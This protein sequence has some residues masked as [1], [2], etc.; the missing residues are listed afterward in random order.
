MIQSVLR[1]SILGVAVC[2]L[3]AAL[4]STAL[5]QDDIGEVVSKIKIS[6]TVGNFQEVLDD[7]DQFGRSLVDLGD[8]NG[9]SVIDVLV[10]AHADDDGGEDHGAVYVMFMASIGKVSTSQKISETSGG[11]TGNLHDFD[12]FGRAAVNLGDLDGD[13]VTD[14]A[15][16]VNYDNEGGFNRGS[17]YVLFLNT[18]GTVKAQQ[19]ISSTEGG[20]GG[21]LD[22]GDEFGRALARIGDLDGDGVTELGVGSY[23]D[24]GGESRGAV[25]ILNLNTN[26]TVKSWSKISSTSGNLPGPLDNNDFFGHAVCALGDIDADGLGDIA[27]GAPL[28]DDGGLNR[29]AVYVLT[30]TAAGT[31]ESQVKISDTQGGFTGVLDDIDQFGVSLGQV[32]DLDGDGVKELAAGAVK[33]DDGGTERGAVWILLLNPDRSVKG[34]AKISDTEGGFN[35]GLGDGD[36]LGSCIGML[37][38]TAPGGLGEIG[39][40]ARFDDD[41][42]M[43]R[44]SV[45]LLRLKDSTNSAPTAGFTASPTSGPAPLTVDF[46]DISGGLVDAWDWDFGDG[47]SS[48][49][50]NPSHQFALPGSYTVSLTV[51]GPGGSDSETKIGFVTVL[52]PTPI[53]EFIGSPTTGTAPLVVSFSDLSLGNGLSWSWDFGDGQTSTVQN[54]VTTYALA[55]TYTVALTATNAFGSDTATKVGYVVVSLA[56]PP[57]AAFAATPQSG[58][59][60]HTVFFDDESSGTITSWAWDF[61]DGG[62]SSEQD[63]IHVYLAPGIYDVTLTV[64]GPGGSDTI[65]RTGFI[66]VSESPPVAEFSGSPT[67]GSATL[68]VVFIDASTGPPTSWAWDFGDGQTSTLQ[69]PGVTYAVPGTFTVSLTASNGVGAD[70]ETKIDYVV[71]TVPPPLAEFSGSPTIGSAPLMVVFTDASS[72]LPT[73]WAWDFGDGQISTLQNPS[74]T[75][76]APG[77][78]TVSLTASNSS[79]A[80]AEIKVDYVAVSAAPPAAEFSGS[81]TSGL[82]PLS[83]SFTDL[84]TGDVTSWLWDFGDGGTSALAS[85]SHDYVL[86]GTYDVTLTATGPGGSDAETKLGY[87]V[88]QD[89]L[90]PAAEFSGSPTSG[91]TPLSVSFT[92]LSTGDVTSW[93]WDFGDGGTSALASPSHDYVLAGT[94]DVTLTATGPGGSDAETKLGY[95]VVQDPLPPLSDGSFELQTPDVPPSGAWQIS[96]GADHLVDSL[97]NGAENGLPSDGQNWALVSAAGTSASKPPSVPGGLTSPAEG[98]AGIQQVFGFDAAATQLSFEAAFV[99]SGAPQDAADNDWMSVDISDGQST[100][101]LFY[102]DSFSDLPNSSMRDGLPMTSTQEVV[103]DLGALFPFATAATALTLSI[104]AGN[105]ASDETSSRGLVDD[106]RLETTEAALELYGCTLNPSGSIQ[107]LTGLPALG[108]NVEIALD[109][110]LGT[111]AAGGSTFLFFAFA[112][113]PHYPCGTSVPGFGMIP[114]QPGE[115]LINLLPPDPVLI[116]VGPAWSGTGSP[117]ILTVSVPNDATLLALSVFLQGLI[118]DP[119]AAF[120]VKFGLTQGI[121]FRVGP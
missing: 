23:D 80:D 60:P 69:N 10:G 1:A 46:T 74:V 6:D 62:T 77:T 44:G 93:L 116:M 95:I 55:G 56:P 110:P 45:Y 88:V 67:S 24:D 36:W 22:N 29:G 47:Q 111:Q 50:R 66:T 48:F 70:T 75:Y 120:G 53:A 28:D 103:V 61:G 21:Q 64:T 79:G 104:Q 5:A 4:G 33:D 52:D 78:Y 86:A 114:G 49:L 98:G 63:P 42:G 73:S 35:G 19:K 12:Q 109:N 105:G 106:F 59:A 68:T 108:T 82:T 99:L 119:T 89:P 14:I 54:P 40:G 16:G 115:L 18:D 118:I 65:T 32:R 41:G 97:A 20:F 7:N 57:T 107:A 51:S 96:F 101:N 17:I 72:G 121:V 113:D 83:V 2:G 13:G 31:V 39:V 27:V 81:P 85:P 91:L 8:L 15:V 84:S 11:F 71:V 102:A 76:T 26:G 112:P 30:L 37:G 117:S 90:P 94:Y 43:N 87:I 9:D 100:W 58:P 25:W 38:G 34:H 92:D 3:L